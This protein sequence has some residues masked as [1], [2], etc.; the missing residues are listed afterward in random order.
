[1]NYLVSDDSKRGLM[2][3]AGWFECWRDVQAKLAQGTSIY[4]TSIHFN[5]IFILKSMKTSNINQVRT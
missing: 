3:G 2:R 1:M 4:Q 5:N